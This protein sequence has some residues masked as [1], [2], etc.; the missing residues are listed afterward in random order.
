[1]KLFYCVAQRVG[2]WVIVFSFFIG[3]KDIFSEIQMND[4]SIRSD[5]IRLN[6]RK[7]KER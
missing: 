1:M 4:E 6:E 7:K 5:Q 2:G 3:A